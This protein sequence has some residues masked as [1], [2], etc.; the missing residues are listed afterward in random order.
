LQNLVQSPGKG[1]WRAWPLVCGVHAEFTQG[2]QNNTPPVGGFAVVGFVVII[3]FVVVVS[4]VVV[5]GAGALVVRLSAKEGD[6]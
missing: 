1:T 6:L 3:G 5:I 2:G 4:L